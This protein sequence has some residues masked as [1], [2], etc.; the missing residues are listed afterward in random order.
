MNFCEVPKE[1]YLVPMGIG[2]TALARHIRVS[3]TRIE[4]ILKGTV[5][6]STDKALRLACVL[7][8]TPYYWLNIQTNFDLSKASKAIDVSGIKPL[9]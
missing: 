3:Q 9:I 8:T 6:I 4:R 1:L 5:G 2:A 7:K